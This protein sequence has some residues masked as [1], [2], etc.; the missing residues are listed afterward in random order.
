MKDAYY[1]SHDANART[2]PKILAMRS[3]YGSEGY[4]LYWMVVETLREQS[5]YKLPL[6][7][8][9]INALALQM[10]Y[11]CSKFEQ[12][13]N[14]CCDEF[15]L[16]QRDESFLWCNTLL[17]RMGRLDDIREKRKS[18]AE[19]RW[20]K[21]KIDEPDAK[22]MQVH[23]TSNASYIQ[24]KVKN[25]IVKDS[26]E[27]DIIPYAE[28][29]MYLNLK[30]ATKYKSNGQKTRDLIKARWNNGFVLEDFKTVID[31]KCLQWLDDPN[32]NQYLRPETLF[33]NKFEGY[34]NQKVVTY[35]THGQGTAKGGRKDPNANCGSADT[36]Y[37]KSYDNM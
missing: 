13:I 11:D 37:Q 30:A 32:N 21:D 20:G 28:I 36:D 5:E 33:G 18:A 6:M 4:G 3:V 7:K 12:F 17:K 24:S 27:E 2:D 31:K 10:Q 9:T 16:L 29:I 15:F 34:L 22:N 8:Y 1:F 19:K 14:D 23:S 26:K 35:G 25:S